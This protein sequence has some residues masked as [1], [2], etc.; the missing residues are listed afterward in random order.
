MTITEPSLRIEDLL[1]HSDWVRSLA[2][3]LVVDSSRADDLVQDT[4]VVALRRPPS[5]ANNL[6]AWLG[7]VVTSLAQTTWRTESRRSVREQASARHEALPSTAELVHEA[8][9]SRELVDGVLEL[10][11]PFRTVL[12][13][14]YF[15]DLTPTQIA[16][17]L[18]RPVPT[19]KTQLQRGLGKL[20]D[21]FDETYI[22]RDSWCTALL[23]LALAGAPA[24]STI[25]ALIPAAAALVG[26]A[27][28]AGVGVNQL[29]KP[30]LAP[31]EVFAADGLVP[32]LINEEE[33]REDS[34][35]TPGLDRAVN[36]RES[37][38]DRVALATDS[39]SNE[40]VPLAVENVHEL[41]GRLLDET[42]NGLDGVVLQWV[43]PGAL[44]WVDEEQTVIS[45]PHLW[46][47]I[48]QGLLDSLQADPQALEQFALDNFNRPGLAAAFLS[49]QPQ[50]RIG[51]TT[52]AGGEF[53]IKT[54]EAGL[55]IE[56][57][58]EQWGILGTAALEE[59][60]DRR[61]WFAGQRRIYIGEV[62][63]ADLEPMPDLEL[64]FASHVPILMEHRIAEEDTYSAVAHV[65]RSD[66]QG[67]VHLGSIA[68]TAQFSVFVEREGQTSEILI[69]LSGQ[70]LGEEVRFQ[71]VL[72]PAQVPEVTL[73]GRVFLRDGD[74][75]PRAIVVF[76]QSMT[77]TDNTGQY[78]LELFSLEGDL[79]A[80]RSGSGIA[81]M[82]DAGAAFEKLSG[83]QPG[84]DL[85]LPG[86]SLQIRGRVL[87]HRSEPIP[88]A[89][90]SLE[91]GIPIPGMMYTLEDLA[92]GRTRGHV[93]SDASGKYSLTGL[94]PRNYFIHVQVG[95][96]HVTVG[97]V[98][99]GQLGREIQL[100]LRD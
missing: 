60:L 48:S 12:L 36:E 50:P 7:R 16:R 75:A 74:P 31:H 34:A 85:R 81:V 80:G 4:W 94:L 88:G 58:D 37:E 70:K 78:E 55:D 51:T 6:R 96:H 10:S 63:D 67:E 33:T 2:H 77:H 68:L 13:L 24:L 87:D 44:Q 29:N 18:G 1:Q 89:L 66:E 92:G 52:R 72:P 17:E 49:G 84:P 43:D 95:D 97:P 61:A 11:E 79:Q 65:G 27:V 32:P 41:R 8:S 20:R 30:A 71:I 59:E 15:R 64:A 62:V 14:R 38:V 45:A 57:I 99:A 54:P 82:T 9:M 26:V 28:L 91:G 42:G 22:D 56:V 35:E 40:A 3:Q 21:R 76:G 83:V 5:H 93:E 86:D 47:P 23:P 100:D 90:V 46:L 53:E 25:P 69:D 19:V 39:G 73:V 98:A